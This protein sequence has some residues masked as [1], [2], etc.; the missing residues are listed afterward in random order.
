MGKVI[1]LI[2]LVV[3]VFPYQVFAQH[4]NGK[5]I[6]SGDY[7]GITGEF[8]VTS[9]FGDIDEGAAGANAYQNNMAYKL[10]VSRNFNSLF[11]ISGRVSFGNMSGQK[12]RESNGKTTYFYF[13]NSFIEYTLDLGINLLAIF[14]KNYNKKFG[15]Y[16]SIGI[17]LVDFRVKL[18]DGS[19]DTVV[20][21]YGYG[22]E[23]ST[24]EFVLP[25]GIRAIYHVSP[26]SAISIQTTSSRVDT[27]KLDAVTGR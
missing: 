14:T 4:A 25:I 13:K 22:G 19:S 11:D 8:G 26:N 7:L 9:F 2:L 20:R 1:Y 16:G 5:N 23:K 21:T 10:Q 3:V 17:G 12:I 15:L 6:N 27:D 18:Y 24:T